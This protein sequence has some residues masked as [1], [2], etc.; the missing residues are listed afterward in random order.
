MSFFAVSKDHR[1]K[2][3]KVSGSI[4][5]P[6]SEASGSHPTGSIYYNSTDRAI[7]YSTGTSVIKLIGV[8]SDDDLSAISPKVELMA[9]ALFNKL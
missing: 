4:T 1:L 7:Y 3:L 5:L 2:N 9:G 8:G 6:T